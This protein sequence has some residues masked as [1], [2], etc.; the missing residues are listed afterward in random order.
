MMTRSSCPVPWVMTA[1][2]PC[3]EASHLIM[4]DLFGSG[5]DKIGAVIRAVLS[6]SKAFCSSGPHSHFM[7]DPVSAVSGAA[8]DE[9]CHKSTIVVC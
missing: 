6:A 4:K 2:M 5:A 3:L 7:S 1:P 8:T 9:K